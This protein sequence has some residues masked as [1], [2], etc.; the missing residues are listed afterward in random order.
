LS[1]LLAWQLMPLQTMNDCRL[2]RIVGIIT[3]AT[4]FFVEFGGNAE[5]DSD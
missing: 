1:H 2:E 5:K 4:P 3:P